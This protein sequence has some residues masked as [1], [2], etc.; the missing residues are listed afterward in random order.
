MIALSVPADVPRSHAERTS[1]RASSGA[2]GSV[3]PGRTVAS[4][5]DEGSIDTRARDARRGWP[6]AA[7][8]RC[9]G[10]EGVESSQRVRDTGPHRRELVGRGLGRHERERRPARLAYPQ[11]FGISYT[12]SYSV[13]AEPI[14]F[15]A[16]RGAPASMFEV[17]DARGVGLEGAV[18]SIMRIGH[19]AR[20][21][22]TAFFFVGH[23]VGHGLCGN[24]NFT[25][26]SC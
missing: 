14:V 6:S 9:D 8:G 15:G 12:K 21:R 5:W 16:L 1:A 3:I 10:V 20:V 4:S 2:S 13:R 23:L 22:G 25:A 26:R 18:V 17:D 7:R 19:A 24:Q 11:R